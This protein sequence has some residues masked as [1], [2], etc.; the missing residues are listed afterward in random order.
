LTDHEK[1]A[2]TAVSHA[3]IPA[4]GTAAPVEAGEE[5]RSRKIARIRKALKRGEYTVNAADVADKLIDHML[6]KR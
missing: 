5:P 2:K 3:E 6:G 1:K 4:S